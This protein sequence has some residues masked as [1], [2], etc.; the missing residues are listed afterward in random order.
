MNILKQKLVI[1]L[2]LLMDVCG[3]AQESE[4]IY[5]ENPLMPHLTY[6]M[7][8]GL[9]YQISEEPS[10]NNTF[11]KVLMTSYNYLKRMNADVD[12]PIGSLV[13]PTAIQN[14]EGDFADKYRVVYI[15]ANF[16][17]C[18]EI[19]SVTFPENMKGILFQG[20]SF[21]NTTQ[22]KCVKF[23]DSVSNMFV[24]PGAFQ[25]SGI[26]ELDLPNGIKSIP[27]DTFA[28]SKISKITIPKSVSKIDNSAFRNCINLQH[29]YLYAQK[30][31]QIDGNGSL[32]ADKVTIHVSA[33]FIE[34]YKS[35]PMWSNYNVIGDL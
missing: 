6:I 13:I 12:K 2:F 9:F 28:D 22:L 3:Y 14:G 29:V 32:F 7:K 15:D 34:N 16:D 35:D 4:F 25:G 24:I 10:D 20:F 18:D 21:K 31:P 11:G 27:R 5:V 30:S 33:S 23:P 8:D 1:L 26:E 19:T 17:N